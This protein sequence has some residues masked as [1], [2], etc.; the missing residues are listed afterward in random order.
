MVATSDYLPT[1]NTSP[2][3]RTSCSKPVV[4]STG[5]ILLIG[6]FFTLLSVLSG[7]SP[8]EERL[9]TTPDYR[10]VSNPIPGGYQF[11]IETGHGSLSY[12]RFLEALSDGDIALINVMSTIMRHHSKAQR[13][14]AVF[15]EC[16][17][18]TANSLE[19][20]PI[21]FVLLDAPALATRAND[22]TAFQ[23]QFHRI[24]HS[25]VDGV[26]SFANL[27][28]D[29]VLVVP[30]PSEDAGER[31]VYPQYMTHLASFHDGAS[32]AHIYNLWK[33][34]GS[35]FL[36]VLRQEPDKNKKFWL[37][38]SGLGVSWLHIRIDAKPKYYNYVEYKVA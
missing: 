19:T 12:G 13:F 26:I 17:P 14:S 7:E 22:I 5:I 33:A 31:P 28:K 23:D 10:V 34:V 27:G 25:S 30:T 4:L 24:E 11:A 3:K 38:T 36:D 16:H 32:E 15:W 29:A 21:E 20:T 2:S 35:T 8:P 18:V 37:S 6:L 1:F 9:M